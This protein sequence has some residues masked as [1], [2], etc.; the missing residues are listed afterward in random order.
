MAEAAIECCKQPLCLLHAHCTRHALHP[1][2]WRIINRAEHART[3]AGVEAV[4]AAV[5]A[6]LES[7]LLIADSAAVEAGIDVSAGAKRRHDSGALGAALADFQPVPAMPRPGAR[8][9]VQRA[10]IAPMSATCSVDATVPSVPLIT[11]QD[12]TSDPH[13][14]SNAIPENIWARSKP[15]AVSTQL[16]EGP[17]GNEAASAPR[18]P[19]QPVVLAGPAL[20]ANASPSPVATTAAS[21]ATGIRESITKLLADTLTSATRL[22]AESAAIA[23]RSSYWGAVADRESAAFLRVGEVPAM[24]LATSIEAAVYSANGD[25]C[26]GHGYRDRC[27]S[28]VH[29]LRDPA[30]TAL[31]DSVCSGSILP[32]SLATLPVEVLANPRTRAEASAVLAADASERA[33]T[34]GD[35][36]T[37]SAYACPSC[38]STESEYREHGTGTADSRKAEVSEGARRGDLTHGHAPLALRSGARLR[39]A[40]RRTASA[41]GRA[42]LRGF[43]ASSDVQV[44]TRACRAPAA[45]AGRAPCAPPSRL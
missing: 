12:A 35:T 43:A 36:W 22:D 7:D 30:N 11:S 20:A 15:Q 13:T 33:F 45:G 42:G 31:R 4:R 2:M 26:D 5:I 40:K 19:D 44:V 34:H 10:A 21:A 27:R 14:R 18:P 6:Q 24:L 16:R 25:N 29:A 3:A 37:A 41:A 8:K 23:G 17:A 1:A 32:A 28:L 38:G 39:R 9:R